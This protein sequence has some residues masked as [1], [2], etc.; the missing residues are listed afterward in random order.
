MWDEEESD[1]HIGVHM[2]EHV[3]N[4]QGYLVDVYYILYD[5]YIFDTVTPA[6]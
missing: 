1:I 2:M 5:E 6:Q 4:R 3:M